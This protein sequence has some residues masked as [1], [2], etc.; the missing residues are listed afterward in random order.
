M[1]FMVSLSLIALLAGCAGAATLA[2]RASQDEIKQEQQIQSGLANSAKSKGNAEKVTKANAGH[3]ERLKRLAP[4]IQEGGLKVCRSMNGANFNCTYNFV[5]MKEGPIN[6][7]ADGKSIHVSPAMMDFAVD[8]NDLS[9]VLAHEYAHNM[10]QHVAKTQN[11]AGVGGLLGTLADAALQSQGYSTG[12][13]L[14]NFGAQQAVMRY[15]QSFESEADYVG[16][17]VA[18]NAGIPIE[19]APDFWRKFAAALPDS[20]YVGTTHPTSAERFVSLEKTMLEIMWKQQQKQPIL[21]NV[22]PES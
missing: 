13:A 9:I 8:D 12:G 1:R 7:F 3:L 17:Y 6:A 14:G 18:A 4:R 2:P 22:I 10:L 5:L 11:N 19:K 15:S 21:P 20:I 16:L